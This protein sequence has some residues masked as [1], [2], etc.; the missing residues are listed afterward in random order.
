MTI[1][2]ITFPLIIFR[3]NQVHAQDGESTKPTHNC[4]PAFSGQDKFWGYDKARWCCRVVG[5]ACPTT[6]PTTSLPFDCNQEYFNWRE[7]W[8]AGKQAWCCDHF[9]K[10]CEIT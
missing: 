9:E 3:M 8:S 10:G 7:K 6:S 5:V 4:T 1:A 2:G